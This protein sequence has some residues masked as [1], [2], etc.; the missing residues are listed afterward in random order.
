MEGRRFWVK[1]KLVCG[2]R[3]ILVLPQ[4]AALPRQMLAAMM[5]SQHSVSSS[6]NIRPRTPCHTQCRLGGTL[7]RRG[8]RFVQWRR[9]GNPVKKQDPI[10]HKRMDSPNTSL[11]AIDLNPT[12]PKQAYSKACYWSW[13]FFF[14]FF[15]SIFILLTRRKATEALYI[16]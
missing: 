15:I 8:L 4:A 1:H 3:F 10:A 9:T 16:G 7:L 14:F 6:R 5:L 12:C 11:Q 2:Q 13:V